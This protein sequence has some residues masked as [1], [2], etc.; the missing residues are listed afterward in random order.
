M[1]IKIKLEGFDEL[2]EKIQKAGGDID[3]ATKQ[4]LQ[5]SADIMQSE[6]KAQMQRSDV[7]SGLINRMPPPE[8]ET[9]GNR[10]TA[11]VGYKKG[12]YDPRNPSDGYKVVFANYGTPRRSKHGQQPTKGFI[13]K[14]KK[15]AKPKIKKAQAETLDKILGGLKG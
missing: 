15:K 14:A 2:L 7:D 9:S 11:R 1:A 13:Q 4:C 5:T 12:N 3:A 6:L 8:I 10:H